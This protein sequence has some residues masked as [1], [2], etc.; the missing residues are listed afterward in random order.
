MNGTRVRKKKKTILQI[1]PLLICVVL[2]G[3]GFV[4]YSIAAPDNSPQKGA[5]V[6]SLTV[7]KPESETIPEQTEQTSTN[8]TEQTDETTPVETEP[9]KKEFCKVGEHYFDDALFLGNS[10]TKWFGYYLPLGDATYYGIDMMTIY[11]VLDNTDTVNGYTGVYSVL[12]AK[13][14]GKVY[15]SFGINECGFSNEGFMESYQ[16]LIDVIRY[17]QPDA[18]IYVQSIMYTTRAK[19]EK[20]TVF[21]SSVIDN[22][23][24]AIKEL[25]NGIDIFYLDVNE[26]VD[27]GTGY[28]K[29]EYTGDG[30]HLYPE[31]YE[32][33][34]DFLY[35]HGIVDADHPAIASKNRR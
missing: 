31:Y 9:Q 15:V 24:E 30:V 8:A 28:M 25:D 22:K 20:E 33:W 12:A 29:S 17:Y 14:Y 6:A 19:A 34:R 10:R 18:I 11:D 4:I 27:D 7:Q 3:I 2:F 26:F 5:P 16:E 35:D 32:L 1:C 13:T 21:T 23:N